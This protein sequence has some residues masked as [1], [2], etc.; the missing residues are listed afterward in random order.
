MPSLWKLVSYFSQWPFLSMAPASDTNSEP[1][2]RLPFQAL[3]RAIAFLC[4]RHSKLFRHYNDE[5]DAD[6]PRR[7]DRLV[8]EYIFRALAIGAGHGVS[9]P[10]LSSKSPSRSLC[11]DVLDTLNTVQPV[12][13]E[14]THVMN[15]DK[16]VPLA[17]RLLSSPGAP[18]PV[19]ALSSL[20]VLAQGPGGLLQ[21]L[22]LLV[23]L[24]R[25]ATKFD[26]TP[27]PGLLVKDLETARTELQNTDGISFDDFLK[28]LGDDDLN[29]YDAVALLFNTLTYPESLTDGIGEDGDDLLLYSLR[30]PGLKLVHH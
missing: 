13:N 30:R 3:A 22:D 28:L 16:L 5:K 6:V 23:L 15:R 4:G 10:K 24:L 9:T 29:V 21:L 19:L 7:K 25:H 18:A 27:T 2:T 12:M 26:R 20:T 11:D 1:T 17:T 14:C 8:L